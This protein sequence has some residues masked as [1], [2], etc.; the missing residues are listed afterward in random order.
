MNNHHQYSDLK[1]AITGGSFT[2]FCKIF[3]LGGL[4]LGDLGKSFLLGI[5]GAAGGWCF[6]YIKKKFF[7]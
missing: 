7:N 5:V 1:S 3:V 6:N 2:I 4:T